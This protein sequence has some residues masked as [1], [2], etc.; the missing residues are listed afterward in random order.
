ME[1]QRAAQLA[2]APV[3]APTSTGQGATIGSSGTDKA[4]TEGAVG[5]TRRQLATSD[6]GGGMS[7]SFGSG[8]PGGATTFSM[9]PLS[10]VEPSEMPDYRPAFK[11]GA[12][13]GDA[14]GNLWIR[15]SK[16]VNGGTVYDVVNNKGELKDRIAV[17]TGRIIAGFGPGGVVYMGVVDATGVTHL[18]RARVPAATVGAANK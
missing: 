4:V 8:G 12:S 1:N 6:G 18:E 15:T 3:S 7:I 10:F 11:Q 17:P 14:D 13:R 16:M 2:A 9:P 5:T